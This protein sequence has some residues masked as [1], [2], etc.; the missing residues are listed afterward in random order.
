MQLLVCPNCGGPLPRHARWTAVICAYCGVAVSPGPTVVSRKA[1]R[2]AWKAAEAEVATSHADVTVNGSRWRLLGLLS[3]GEISDVFRAT[4]AR[5]ITERAVVKLLRDPADADLFAREW[6]VLSALGASDAQGAAHFKDLLPGLIARGDAQS[7]H[8]RTCPALVERSRPG[9]ERTLDDVR[10]A[11]PDGVDP[12]HAVWMWRRV[13]EVLGWV[14]RSGWVHGAVLPQHVVL[15]TG[16]H[17]ATI[18]GWS[19]AVRNGEPLPAICAARESFYPADERTGGRARVA[20]DLVMAA[21]CI[22]YVLGADDPNALPASVPPSLR[23]V[24]EASIA[25]GC[26]EDAWQLKEVVAAAARRAFGSPAFV[27]LTIPPKERARTSST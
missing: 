24:V 21:R 17:G 8:G 18:V 19:C 16:E 4:R 1:Y 2:R 20:S 26:P 3:H 15:H 12:R 25:G 22:A 7:A 9:F 14:H 13:L 11:F 10:E 6:D 23:E 5:R 27:P